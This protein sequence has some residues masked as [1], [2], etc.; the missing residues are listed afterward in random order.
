MSAEFY[1]AAYSVSDPALAARL[2]EWR[3]LGARIK[4][5]HIRTLVPFPVDSIV[6]IGCGDGALLSELAGL[7]PVLDGFEIVEPA[8]G[9]ARSRGVARRVELFNGVDLD[10]ADDAYS[11]AILSHVVE[12]IADPLP[13][14]REAARVAP[15]VLVEVPL[16][17]N[18]SARRPAK[19]AQ[20]ARIGHVQFFSRESLH[21]LLSSADLEVVESLSDPLPREHHAFF[22]PGVRTSL[23]SALR[24]ALWRIAPR[25]AERLF[26]VHYAV[27]A[28]RLFAL[29]V[30]S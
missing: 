15:W 2:G 6:E 20:A 21:A 25:A 4:A 26:T 13:V 27:L 1:E 7:A 22:S 8:V 16:E 23:K 11:I 5:G 17:D 10:V 30:N 19:R 3:A 28:R 14:L 18:R 12:H 29:S 9:K 24:R